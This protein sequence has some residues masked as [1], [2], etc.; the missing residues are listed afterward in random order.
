LIVSGLTAVGVLAALATF[1][2][3]LAVGVGLAVAA[4]A[5]L[6]LYLSGPMRE[7]SQ[8]A[9]RRK[10]NLAA[11]VSRQVGG[12]AVVQVHGQSD[13]ER[14]RLARQS[15]KLRDAAVARARIG[16]RLQGVVEAT[17]ALAAAVT[18]ALG[19]VEIGA[20]RATPGAVAAALA[21]A[22]L[23]AP[24][25]SDLSRVEE[26]R[27]TADVA[28]AKIREFLAGDARLVDPPDASPLRD[29]PG[30]LEFVAVTLPGALADV[31]AVA[32]AGMR[33][34]LVGRNG[35]GKSS[36]LSLACRLVEPVSGAVLLDG[37][38]LR[39][40]TLASVRRAVGIVGPDLPLL[41][42]TV[43]ENL[44]YRWPEAPDHE[45]ARV[46]ELCGLD[47]LLA[48]LPDGDR[49]KLVDGGANLSAGQ[50]QRIALARAILDEPR[51]LLLDEADANLDPGSS[52]AFDRVL[53]EFRGTVLL[54]THRPDRLT[55]VDAIWHL[56]DGKLVEQG[57]PGDV[58]ARIGPTRRLFARVAS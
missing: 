30:R 42:G 38:E 35:A 2:A 41:R 23:L 54:A 49:T 57:P 1:N 6:S 28:F 55:A 17:S 46:R 32:E 8:E 14:R 11:N 39:D 53:T 10:S 21:I 3:V 18:L 56:E 45:L 36:L 19:S 7:A 33:I 50:R 22:G 31:S 12:L 24:S 58:L 15:R 4:G 27:R 9:R 29:G 37:R 43:A 51:L 5:G 25:L 44:R 40:C 16:G 26:Y 47:D 20:G 34:A 13:R 52:T 48:E